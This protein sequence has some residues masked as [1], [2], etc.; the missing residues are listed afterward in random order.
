MPF[1]GQAL[2]SL[3]CIL[4]IQVFTKAHA[5]DAAS[6]S[7]PRVSAVNKCASSD[8]RG[9]RG[10]VKGK[11]LPFSLCLPL[12]G[13]P[14]SLYFSP[15]A[16]LDRRALMA[17]NTG[18]LIPSVPNNFPPSGFGALTTPLSWKYYGTYV[19]TSI[20][21]V[22]RWAC[23]EHTALFIQIALHMYINWSHL[24]LEVCEV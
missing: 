14:T 10:S 12:L 17:P 22:C 2:W 9:R 1:K 6:E 16:Q 24:G 8:P 20:W 19:C 18:A 15:W 13:G 5:A 3:I 7:L 23:L 21:S 4:I 11:A